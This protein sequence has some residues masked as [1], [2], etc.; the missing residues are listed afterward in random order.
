ML[1]GADMLL[2]PSRYEPCGLSQLYAMRFGTAP[3]VRRVGGLADTVIGHGPATL[4]VSTGFVFDGEGVIDVVEAVEAARRLH[5]EPLAWRK[6]LRR[7][8]AAD[9]GWARSAAAYAGLYAEAT[10]QPMLPASDRVRRPARRTARP[11][12]D[13]VA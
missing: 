13:A 9:F 3:I 10:G 1:A 7:A 2:M 8:M 5:A 4:D 12:K 11:A 6:L